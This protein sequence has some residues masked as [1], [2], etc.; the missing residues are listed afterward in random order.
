MSNHPSNGDQPPVFRGLGYATL[1]EAIDREILDLITLKDGLSPVEARSVYD[2]DTIARVFLSDASAGFMPQGE[3]C[4]FWPLT[5]AH[6]LGIAADV[7]VAYPEMYAHG[8]SA[9]LARTC[10]ECHAPDRSSCTIPVELDGVTRRAQVIE[11][12]AA[13]IRRDDATTAAEDPARDSR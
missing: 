3:T 7:L 1:S 5:D 13:R 6:R 9:P 4:E 12:H 8:P 10:P 2:I 11:F